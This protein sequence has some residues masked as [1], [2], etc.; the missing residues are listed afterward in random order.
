[1]SSRHGLEIRTATPADAP[2]VAELLAACGQPV[3]PADLA[4]RLDR[5]QR[6]PGTALLAMEHGP[7]S[8]II[9]THWYASL[10]SNHPVAEVSLLLVG[11]DERRRGLGRL[12]LKAASQAAR[13]AGCHEIGLQAPPDA[14]GLLGFGYDT[15]FMAHNIGLRRK[16]RRTSRA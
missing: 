5:L 12:L 6:A 11:P 14:P 15:G 7:P 3:A 16:L 13:S 10:A 8:G 1:M 4:L 2:Q 9:V